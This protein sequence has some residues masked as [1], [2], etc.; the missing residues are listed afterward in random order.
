MR[1]AE[2]CGLAALT[3]DHVRVADRLRVNADLKIGSVMA[4]MVAGADSIEDLDVLR[5]A[6]WPSC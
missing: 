3:V 1:L 6:A 4:G 5:T 2:K